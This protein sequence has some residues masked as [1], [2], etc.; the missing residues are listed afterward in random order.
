MVSGKH[1]KFKQCFLKKNGIFYVLTLTTLLET[2]DD[3][4]EVGNKILNS[5][6]LK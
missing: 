1:L 3:Y 2:F 5:F 4:I 6:K